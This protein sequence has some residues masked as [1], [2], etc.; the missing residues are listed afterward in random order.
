M[1]FHYLDSICFWLQ[2][3]I[4]V[5]FIH[6]IKL[7]FRALLRT[8]FW[9]L[10]LSNKNF[11]VTSTAY[12]LREQSFYLELPWL[13]GVCIGLVIRVIQSFANT[14]PTSGFEVRI[15]CNLWGLSYNPFSVDDRRIAAKYSLSAE[16]IPSESLLS[17]DEENC[18]S[19]A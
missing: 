12:K 13:D 7:S 15:A 2:C 18:R 10:N 5:Y 14:M 9:G 11:S 16:I 4:T 1:N 19:S 3:I 17:P 8:V 6:S